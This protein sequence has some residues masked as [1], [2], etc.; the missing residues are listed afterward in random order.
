MTPNKRRPISAK[1]P[2]KSK[3]SYMNKSVGMYKGDV[4]YKLNKDNYP[5]M[6]HW[7]S[8]FGQDTVALKGAKRA[9]KD[10][11]TVQERPKPKTEYQKPV[12]RNPEQVVSGVAP[13]QRRQ[14][15]P[16]QPAPV[17]KSF[18]TSS[19]QHVGPGLKTTTT[20]TE[21]SKMRTHGTQYE[22]EKTKAI[23]VQTEKQASTLPV[24]AP[25]AVP[26]TTKKVTTKSEGVQCPEKPKDVSV[27]GTQSDG[28]K[29]KASDT[30]TSPIIFQAKQP[31]P[32]QAQTRT[33]Q[34][35][36][37]IRQEKTMYQKRP[38][39]PKADPVIALQPRQA[40]PQTSY[41][42]PTK[43]ATKARWT[44]SPEIAQSAPVYATVK[45]EPQTFRQNSLNNSL[46]KANNSGV[47]FKSPSPTQTVQMSKT[48]KVFVPPIEHA[49][50]ETPY[51]DNSST[52]RSTY[53]AGYGLF[54]YS[55]SK[56][57]LPPEVTACI[58]AYDIAHGPK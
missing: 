26:Q 33:P 16:P 1:D 22:P 50:A 21:V 37:E 7:K 43:E 51:P 8:G 34:Y 30:Q 46:T 29:V 13:A 6:R 27:K 15:S 54:P 28:P 40:T 45:A 17:S 3:P 56:S 44:P 31:S 19:T 4:N 11:Y 39:S 58:E 55:T 49:Q 20:Q 53:R 36:E 47:T 48:P 38:P 42:P 18:K 5:A 32:V 10:N 41:K 24:V 25:V 9:P 14:K 57:R 35:A 2:L 12:Q 52:S 23:S